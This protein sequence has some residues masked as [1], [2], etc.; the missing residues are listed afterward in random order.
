MFAFLQS[1]TLA[2]LLHYIIFAAILILGISI[3]AGLLIASYLYWLLGDTLFE[4]DTKL[5][6]YVERRKQPRPAQLELPLGDTE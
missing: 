4:N 3:V 1:L 5:E 2:G 6:R